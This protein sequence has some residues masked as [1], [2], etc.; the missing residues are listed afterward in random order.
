MGIVE[1]LEEQ[2][3]GAENRTKLW[4]VF[5]APYNSISILNF[6]HWCTAPRSRVHQG[7]ANSTAFTQLK[8]SLE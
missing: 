6:L 2:L 1:G 7:F 4:S 8:F 3:L 5:I